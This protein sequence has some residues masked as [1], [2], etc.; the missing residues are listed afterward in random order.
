[1]GV[2][3][4]WTG[5]IWNGMVEFKME[6]NSECTQLQLT[7]VTGVAQSSLVKLPRHL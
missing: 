1:M 7:R 4:R 3:N 6:R 2:S 5:I